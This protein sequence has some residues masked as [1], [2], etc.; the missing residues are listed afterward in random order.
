MKEK[1]IC[2]FLI[3]IYLTH[4][5]DMFGANT[6]SRYKWGS[7]YTDSL[8]GLAHAMEPRYT[9]WLIGSLV[10]YVQIDGNVVLVLL[11]P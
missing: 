10:D 4:G 2:Y 1:L 9:S 8:T 6:G 11:K 3:F 5:D 7:A